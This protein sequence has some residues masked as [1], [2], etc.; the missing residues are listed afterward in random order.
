M[1]PLHLY[2]PRRLDWPKGISFIYRS[3]EFP[4]PDC[5]VR[6]GGFGFQSRSVESSTV[7]RGRS[8]GGSPRRKAKK[9]VREKTGAKNGAAVAAERV[10]KK[11]ER[12]SNVHTLRGRRDSVKQD[13][14]YK[15]RR[16]RLRLVLKD[17]E[18]QEDTAS[19]SAAAM[20]EEITAEAEKT[21]W[22]ISESLREDY[23]RISEVRRRTLN[24]KRKFYFVFFRGKVVA[25]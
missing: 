15:K 24:G 13:K 11:T 21:R 5:G 16:V 25:K 20:Y 23:L 22:T 1:A 10:S 14:R 7:A 17:S 8:S 2:D 19:I 6:S 9:S 18:R 3:D 12:A 4:L